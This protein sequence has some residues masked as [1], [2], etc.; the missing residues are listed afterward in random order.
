MKARIWDSNDD[1]CWYRNSADGQKW[2]W[3]SKSVTKFLPLGII[4][5]HVN[6]PLITEYCP[7]IYLELVD[8]T[9]IPLEMVATLP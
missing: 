6:N 2:Y 7:G 8:G 4:L 3:M 5:K 9:Q 1:T